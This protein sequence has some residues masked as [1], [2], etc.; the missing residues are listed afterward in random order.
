VL[1]YSGLYAGPYW[2]GGWGWGGYGWATA[3]YPGPIVDTIVKVE[4][5]VYSLPDNKLLWAGISNTT[6]P[7]KLDK[8]VSD[9]AKKATKEMEKQG[10]IV[11]T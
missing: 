7:S 6:D 9:V 2:G 4:T 11:G 5:K 10:L 1:N 3:G 8:M